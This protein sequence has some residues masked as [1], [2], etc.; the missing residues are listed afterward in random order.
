[1][2]D[3][4]S[5]L[6]RRLL[7][8]M[9]RD[10]FDRELEEEIRFHLEMKAQENAEAGMETLEARYAAERQFGNQTLLQEVS[11][12]MWSFRSLETLFQDLRY[13]ARMLLKN[14]GFTLIAVITLALGIG[15][16]TA[17]FSVTSAIL[18]RPFDFRDLDRLVWVYETAPQQGNFLSGMSPADFADL[19]RQQKV[20]AGL[21]A[22]RLSNSNLTGGGEPERVRNSEV[23]AEFFRLLGFEATLGRAFL[24]EEEQAGR[25]QV[26]VLGYGLWQRRFGADPKIV[27][28]TIS[29]D[30]KAY[31][32]IGV[33]PEKFDFPKPGELWTPLALSNEAWNERREQSLQVVA[34]L[35]P[36]V[37]LGQVNAEV[38]TL[39]AR[40][41]EQYPQTNAGR[42]ATVRLL[43][44]PPGNEYSEV[45]LSLLMAAAGFVL[46]IACV[47]IANMQ[48]ARASSR[49]R[50]MAVRTAL[51]ASRLALVRQLLTESILLSLLGGVCGLLVSFGLLDFI[52]GSLPLDQVQYI[53]GWESIRVNE[54]VMIFTLVVSLVSSVVFGL[55]PALQSS[56]PNL[57]E[58]LK[59]GGRSDGGGAGGQRLRK[60]LI[61]AEV[62][63]ALVLLVGAGL[64]VKGFARMTEKQ[65][66]GFDPR[67]A[68][69]LRATLPP[70][71]YADGRQIAAFHRQAQER[72]SALPG[73]ESATSTSFLPG[74]DVR[75]STEFQI[76]G[77]PAPP[78]GQESVSSYQQVGADYFR[79]VRIPVINGREFSTDDVE[80][81]PLVAVISE[82]LARRYFPNEDPL[83]RRVKVGA[84]E[85][86]ATWYTIVGVTGDV[87]RLW[88][89]R[90][91]QPM[92]Y[93]PNQ[94]L[95][96]RDAYLV[97]RASGAPMAAVQAVRAQIAA[98]DD[99]LPL[100]EIK[101][102]EQ[103]IADQ[104]AG[105]RLVAALMVMFGALALALAAV[106]IYGVMAY[107]VSQ[108]TREIGVR[109]ALGAR[110]QDVL[111][112]VVGQSLKLAALGLAIGLPVALALGRMMAGALFGVIALE[113]LTFVGFTLLLTGVAMLAGYLPARRATKVDP[114]TALRS[115]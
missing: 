15:A 85:S 66:Q 36:G 52:R 82:T 63:L 83:G 34:R 39:A 25:G 48:L 94:Q 2:F 28:A 13:G 58:A 32:V 105:L 69:T 59:E 68:L 108:R 70:S 75:N 79:T 29:L 72:L 109:V 37:E 9:R 26:A 35:K 98:L 86:V 24:P 40:L 31:T 45:F 102:H 91:M 38:E 43:R 51:G 111:R 104:M 80:G 114:I 57:N 20:F 113:P 103:A 101:S 8:Y 47:N 53:P 62:A 90:E 88:L 99:K 110:P 14:P 112:L 78:P 54:R 93:L 17:I 21:A 84:S 100:Y 10:R 7:F 77:R 55:V 5:Q 71:R 74:R 6:W 95:P 67:H 11:R 60:A 92:L 3:K 4:L 22:F 97:V 44:Q 1:L 106:G 64:M 30:E 18:L 41:A 73:V 27:G 19:R 46:L 115:G 65:Q 50:E 61:V 49:S 23:T 81:A 56:N 33:M 87:P 12:D 89:D 76:E 16:N 42:G 96:G 107:A